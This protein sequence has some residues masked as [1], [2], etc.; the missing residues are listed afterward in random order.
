MAEGSET[1]VILWNPEPL[2]VHRFS[3]VGSVQE[4]IAIA[5]QMIE[6]SLDRF[7]ALRMPLKYL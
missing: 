6:D 1:V 7:I 3:E 4:T 5:I 2:S